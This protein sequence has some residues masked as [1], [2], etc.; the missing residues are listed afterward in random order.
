M[1]GDLDGFGVSGRPGQSGGRPPRSKTLTHAK[2]PANAER[3]GVR[4]PSG[5]L[6]RRPATALSR[7]AWR[8]EA[9]GNNKPSCLAR[10][11]KRWRATALQDADARTKRPA[12]AERPGVRQPSGALDRRPATAFASSVAGP[13]TYM[14]LRWRLACFNRLFSYKYAAPTALKRVWAPVARRKYAGGGGLPICRALTF[15]LDLLDL[16]RGLKRFAWPCYRLGHIE[17]E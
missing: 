17:T 6:A 15:D 9:V 16:T 11:P 14:S 10:R 1:I 3:P 4:Q 5:A 13:K 2:R 8:A 7:A 12:N